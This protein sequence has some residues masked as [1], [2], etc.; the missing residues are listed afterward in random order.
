MGSR[1]SLQSFLQKGFPLQLGL[2]AV[3]IHYK[4]FP[5]EQIKLSNL[6]PKLNRYAIEKS[7]LLNISLKDYN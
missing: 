2:K 5:T 1:F 3:N 4:L 6:L 7:Q